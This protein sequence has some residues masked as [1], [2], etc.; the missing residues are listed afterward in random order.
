MWKNSK[1]QALEKLER[2]ISSGEADRKILPLV[3]KIN[4][5]EKY[6]TTSSCAGRIALIELKNFGSKKES[7]FLKRWHGTVKPEEFEKSLGKIGE[8]QLWLKVEPPILHVKC[9]DLE[10]AQRL[11]NA[12]YN[13]GWKYS[14]IKSLR[15][16]VLVEIGGSERMELPVAIDGERIAGMEYLRTVL[17]IANE[18]LKKAQGKLKRLEKAV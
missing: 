7:G 3:K 14:S 5:H 8:Q 13:T 15:A 16:G 9:A 6:C 12:A 4:S 17:S 11:L 18:K 1:K 2:A 10:S